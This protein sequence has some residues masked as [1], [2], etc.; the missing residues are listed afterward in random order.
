MKSNS[1]KNKPLNRMLTVDEVAYVLHVHPTTVRK[2]EKLGQLKSYRLGAKGNVRFKT[3]DVSYFTDLISRAPALS[4]PASPEPGETFTPVVPP[5]VKKNNNGEKEALNTA[6]ATVDINEQITTALENSKEGLP[7]VLSH[8]PVALTIT[9]LRDNIIIEINDSYTD[10]M[11]YS[12]ADIIGRKITEM[13]VWVNPEERERMLNLLRS[14]GRLVNQ[15]YYFRAKSGETHPVLFSAEYITYQGEGCALSIITDITKRKQILESLKIERDRA[16]RYL[17]IA[18]VIFLSMDTQGNVIL[19]NRKGCEVL[20]YRPEEIIGK[21]WFDNFIPESI[22]TELKSV[23]RDLLSGKTAPSEYHENPVLTRG[24]EERIIAWHNTILTDEAGNITGHLSSGED[25]TE[26]KQAEKAMRE[27]E[28][29]FR[30]L[31]EHAKDAIVVADAATGILLDINPMGC[32]MLGLPRDQIIGKHMTL[33]H[34]PEMAE[35]FKQ[36]FRE[37]VEKGIVLADDS[38]IQRADGTRIPA[39]V[40]AS[41]VRL[42]D[43]TLIQ[44]VFRDISKRRIVEEKLSFS[45]AAFKSL[46]ESIFA[47]DTHDVITYWN[48]MSEELFGVK[49]SEA[50]GKKL[51]DIVKIKQSYPEQSQDLI[52]KFQIHGYNRD[53][54]LFTTPHGQVWVDTTVQQIERDGQRYGNI[55]TALDITERKRAEE[56]LK[57]SE[58][59][60]A[61]AFNVSGNAICITSMPDGKF[62]EIND[63]YTR[64]TGYSRE[65]VIGHTAAELKLWVYPEE[66]QRIIEIL[67]A[68]GKCTNQEFHSRHKSGEIR[69]G[70]NSTE[71]I[72]IK[73][74]TCRIVVIQDITERKK[75]EEALKDSEEKFSRAFTAS[76]NAICIT[77]LK[78]NRFIEVNEAFMRFTGYPREEIIGRSSHDLNVWVKPEELKLWMDTIHKEGRVYNQEFSSRMKSGEI[79]IGLASAEVINIGGEPC[80]IVVITD[81]TDRK[82][83]EQELLDYRSH[84][85]ELVEKRTAQFNT[86][87]E[88]LEDE[89]EERKRIERELLQAK[90]AAE[91]AN[92]AKSDFLARMSHEIRT[93]IHGVIGTLNLIL[94][95]ELK[96]EPRQ[97][98]SMAIAS[99]QSLLGIINDIL[100]FS[101]IEAGQLVLEEND[102][103]LQ[104]TVEDALLPMALA[105]HRKGLEITSRI[106]PE[107]P[108]ELVGDGGRLRQIIVNL[109]GNGV[110]FTQSGEVSVVVTAEKESEDHVELHFCIRDTGIGIP[111]EQQKLLFN[112]F[113]QGNGS[114]YGGTGLGLAICRQLVNMMQGLIWLESQPG[115][116]SAFHLIVKFKKSGSNAASGTVPPEMQQLRGAPAL[117]IDDNAT[118]RLMLTELL[119]SWG[120]AAAAAE[121]EAAAIRQ[122]KE[123]K[124]GSNYPPLIFLDLSM[125]EANGLEIAKILGNDP[126]LL[127]KIILML[128]CDNISDNYNRCHEAG[129]RAHL[130]KPL[131]MH[132]IKNAVI[133]VLSTG[134]EE[135][136]KPARAAPSAI[137]ELNLRILVAEDNPT[138]QLIARKTL[139]RTGCAVQIANNGLEAARMAQEGDFDLVL[140]DFDMPE[141]NGLDATKV[142]REKERET[143]KHLPIVAMTAYAMKQDRD[144]CLEAGMDG[145]LTKPI[146]PDHLYHAISGILP[147]SK[148][149][150]QPVAKSQPEAPGEPPVD[151]ETAMR[152]VGGDEDILKEVL[153]VFLEEDS[154]RLLKSITEAIARQDGKAIKSEAHGMKGAAAAL[155]GRT[156]AA[157][158]ARLEVAGLDG[159]MIAAQT[160]FDEMCHELERFKDFY[161]GTDLGTEG[162]NR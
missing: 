131:K 33:L 159:D 100:D 119:G 117:V 80:R 85:E 18:G 79:R 90:N 14:Q 8:I 38:I 106:P 84:L 76:A 59:K 73:G 7:S 50:I 41:V 64:F 32:E 27:S 58:E 141:M 29:K 149:D 19:I 98:A 46:H 13:N 89:L 151:L 160:I 102:F 24:G 107:V 112:P 116:G 54:L 44:G 88:H 137:P 109:L 30:N 144:K 10:L 127:Q 67:N 104:T 157:A 110:K 4:P 78:D 134:G 16:Q 15:E 108:R 36:I 72:N 53:E 87:T 111:E 133:S 51:L 49:A 101:K 20:G 25:I 93:P 62:V 55:V 23:S 103:D 77:S 35:K 48:N 22:K 68:D 1:V 52:K 118:N 124:D 148:P 125:P 99:A 56:E 154:P 95:A 37:H 2:W 3:E 6:A 60:F 65:E 121:N 161:S 162:G 136:G 63:S 47:V 21:N 105:A 126:Q 70:L 139:E 113:T 34:P 147:A 91:G 142:I 128:P 152:T 123:M 45:D 94:D 138:S 12:R 26:R 69:T 9:R 43:K 39:S 146:N 115:Q 92:R 96:E 81:I 86:L 28:E 83:L 57:D 66:L 158:A 75:A 130:I 5:A 31:F 135:D 74:Q 114:K 129:I 82:R 143:G 153:G 17:D 145:Y 155:G 132:D 42:G 122:L 140:M 61:R 97:Y 156:I 71:I 120:L 40:S 11:G 150:Q